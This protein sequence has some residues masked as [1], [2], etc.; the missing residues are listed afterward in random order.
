MIAFKA[1]TAAPLQEQIADHLAHRIVSGELPDKS[2]LPSTVEL[3]RL[4][5]V[6]P[7]TIH[8]SLQHLV[9]RQLIERQPRRGTF[10]RSYSA[11]IRSATG[12]TSIR[13]CSTNSRSSRSNAP[14]T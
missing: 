11:R 8:K 10:V 3:A 9:Q 5:H 14:S 2:R 12:A 13:S 7:V 1:N 4:Y 6:T